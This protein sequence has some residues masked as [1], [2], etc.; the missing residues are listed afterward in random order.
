MVAVVFMVAGKVAS[1]KWDYGNDDNIIN[2]CIIRK[3][4]GSD[5]RRLRMLWPEVTALGVLP[6]SK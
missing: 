2:G 3:F 6:A 5:G 4:C 1:A